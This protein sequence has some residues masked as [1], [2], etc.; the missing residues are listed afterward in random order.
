MPLW[1]IR[2]AGLLDSVKQVS[3]QISWKIITTTTIWHS[4][5]R[6]YRQMMGASTQFELRTHF[7]VCGRRWNWP[8]KGPRIGDRGRLEGELLLGAEELPT[9]SKFRGR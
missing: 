9:D 1:E 7:I 4:G 3:I 5:G 2:L 6:N 8:L